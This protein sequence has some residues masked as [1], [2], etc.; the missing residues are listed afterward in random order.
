MA[1]SDVAHP[2][3]APVP[4][5]L[6]PTGPIARR[7][8]LAA[9]R[10]TWAGAPLRATG[11]GAPIDVDLPDHQRIRLGGPGPIAARARVRD[12]RVFLRMLLRGEMGAG[13]G[14][15]AGEWDVPDRGRP[16]GS[17]LV[18]VIRGFL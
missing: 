12:D 17:A 8:A 2:L 4:R 1:A 7:L 18:D 9:L 10:A 13:E 3:I 16:A 6:G 15:V 5:M 14:F 11:A